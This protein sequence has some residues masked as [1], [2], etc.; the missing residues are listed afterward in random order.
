MRTLVLVQ[1]FFPDQRSPPIPSDHRRSLA[2]TQH[3]SGTIKETMGD[4]QR[5]L[6]RQKTLSRTSWCDGSLERRHLKTLSERERM[7]QTVDFGLSCNIY[8]LVIF[9]PHFT[10]GHTIQISKDLNETKRLLK[11]FKIMGKKENARN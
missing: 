6:K 4:Y 7:L 11:I 1:N 5:F 8:F 9:L 2:F 10:L 3:S